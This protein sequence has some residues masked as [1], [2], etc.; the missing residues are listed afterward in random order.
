MCGRSTEKHGVVLVAIHE[1]LPEQEGRAVLDKLQ[2]VC[3]ECGAGLKSC[4]GLPDPAWMGAVMSHRS[5]HV[6]LGETLKAF[7]GEPVPAATL[8]FVANQS[9]W[10]KRIREL[11]SLG[12]EI[13]TFNRKLSQGG[14]VSSYYRLVKSRPWPTDPTG[15]IR[16]YERNR[17]LRNR[18]GDDA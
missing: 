11:R 17:A 6:R 18:D 15:V 12:W 14:R 5:V 3:E 13:E 2:V 9:A 4:F 8:N 1:V 10:K 16:Q 7:K